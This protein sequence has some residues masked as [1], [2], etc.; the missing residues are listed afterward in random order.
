MG[1]LSMQSLG[2]FA[3]PRAY[4]DNQFTFDG[5]TARCRVLRSAI[6]G[7]STYY[8]AVERV[9]IADAARAVFAMICLIRYNPQARDG[10]LFA[11]KDVDEDCGPHESTCPRSIL[12]LLTPTSNS[13]ALA[14]RERCRQTIRKRALDTA[15]P[16]PRPGDTIIF[17]E[18]VQFVDGHVLKTMRVVPDPRGG[19]AVRFARPDGGGLFRI[20][21]LNRRSYSLV[22]APG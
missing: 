2:G 7:K 6:V 3:T 18:P 22:R 12:D 5:D 10:Y 21:N 17:T 16:A 11:Y 4:L 15:K 8:A 13:Y 20:P 14:W 9:A 1:W 19:R